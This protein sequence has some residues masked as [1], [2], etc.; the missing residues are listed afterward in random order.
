[1]SKTTDNQFKY[2]RFVHHT[3]EGTR[4]QLRDELKAWFGADEAKKTTAV[5]EAIFARVEEERS[6][7]ERSLDA[8]RDEEREDDALRQAV[9]DGRRDLERVL[10]LGR[11]ALVAGF[12]EAILRTYE[13][14]GSTPRSREGLLRY[15]REGLRRLGHE[16]RTGQDPF[17]KEVDTASIRSSIAK[18]FDSFE[19]DYLALDQDTKE[20]TQER[21]RRDEAE[22]R[23]RR[24]MIHSAQMFEG[25]LRLVKMDYIADRVRPTFARVQGEEEVDTGPIERDDLNS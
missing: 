18:A 22:E 9:E 4:E 15:T 8:V 24:S 10:R 23:Y 5:L 16:P 20:T 21:A 6:A 14:H 7:F 17:G 1:M 3:F 11:Q 19:R 13:L 12:G 2:S 25:A